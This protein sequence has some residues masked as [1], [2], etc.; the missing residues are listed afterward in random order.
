MQIRDHGQQKRTPRHVENAGV[1]K[2]FVL[3]GAG[4]LFGFLLG[5]ALQRGDMSVPTPRKPSNLSLFE[6]QENSIRKF[7][8]SA[9]IGIRATR[10]ENAAGAKTLSAIFDNL[11]HLKAKIIGFWHFIQPVE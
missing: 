1:R 10:H 7:R 8:Q 4:Q 9:L 3:H 6:W 11:I 5:F 2:N